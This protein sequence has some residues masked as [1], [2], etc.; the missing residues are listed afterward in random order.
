[1]A[2]AEAT[3][4]WAESFGFCWRCKTRTGLQ[5]H[6]FVQGS[7]RHKDDLA[8]T[9]I[10]CVTCHGKEHVGSD[11]LGLIGWLALK[12]TYDKRRYRLKHC[13]ELRGRANIAITAHAV[14][15]EQFNLFNRNIIVRSF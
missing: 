6:H 12:R 3:T 11:G 15:A 4:R 8:T 1:M 14:M 5:I 10:A 2:Y 7:S 13:N 9:G